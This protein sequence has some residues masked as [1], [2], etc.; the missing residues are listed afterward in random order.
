MR[1]WVSVTKNTISHVVSSSCFCRKTDPTC[2]SQAYTSSIIRQIE[3]GKADTGE[4]TSASF[5]ACNVLTA[6]S[7]NGPTF[8]CWSFHSFIFNVAAS[9]AKFETD[10]RNMLNRPKK[11]LRSGMLVGSWSPR[12][13]SFVRNRISRRS[14]RITCPK[15]SIVLAKN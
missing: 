9:R 8:F 15:M 14:G 2:S 10:R 13:A 11:H 6:S 12:M 5:N 7:F 4:D 3:L 1:H